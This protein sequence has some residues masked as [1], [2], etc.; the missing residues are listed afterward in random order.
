MAITVQPSAPP[1]NSSDTELPLAEP[2][3]EESPVE[4]RV[5]EPPVE[6]CLE[7]PWMDDVLRELYA[8]RD[9]Y[10]AEHGYDLDRIFADLKRRENESNLRF[11][12]SE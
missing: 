11:S 4:E 8:E 1:K 10:A 3:V 2:R 7:E 5:E 12:E 6:E 9:A